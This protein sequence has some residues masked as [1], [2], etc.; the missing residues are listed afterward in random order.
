MFF[1][2]NILKKVF[3]PLFL[4]L[5][6]FSM[7]NCSKKNYAGKR[8]KKLEQQEG[9]KKKN[10]KKVREKALKQHQDI[11]SK[12]TKKELKKLK[13]KAKKYRRQKKGRK[14]FLFRW[15]SEV[16]VETLPINSQINK[17]II[18]LNYC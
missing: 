6:L 5:F 13:K 16:K 1:L 2:L 11:Q 17:E 7:Q 14:F 8:A 4:F 3:I 18:I 12:S 10:D 9:S 15:F